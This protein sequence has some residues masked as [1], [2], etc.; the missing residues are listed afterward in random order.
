[1][2]LRAKHKEAGRRADRATDHERLRRLE[3]AALGPVFRLRWETR[4]QNATRSDM[5]AVCAMRVKRTVR[6]ARK[7][8]TQDTQRMIKVADFVLAV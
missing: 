8:R 3:R 7:Q 5:R 4:M 6:I 2:N 1:M